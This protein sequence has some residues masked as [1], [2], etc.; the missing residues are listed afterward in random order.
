MI[1][2]AKST[3][4]NKVRIDVLLFLIPTRLFLVPTRLC[5]LV[6]T[7]R[8]GNAFPTRQR[9]GLLAYKYWTLARPQWVPTP[10]RGNQK[11]ALSVHFAYPLYLTEVVAGN[12]IKKWTRES[13]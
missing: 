8:R 12:L 5:F 7:R 4:K 9:R 3:D 6:P 1:S 10:A 2:E 13:D 11:K